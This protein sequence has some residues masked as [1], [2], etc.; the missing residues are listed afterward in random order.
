MAEAN[1][2]F[3]ESKRSRKERDDR[4]LEKTEALSDAFIDFTFVKDGK[5]LHE[6]AQVAEL[7]LIRA[8]DQA[9]ADTKRLLAETQQ[10]LSDTK[11]ELAVFTGLLADRNKK[12]KALTEVIKGATGV[13]L[14]IRC[15]RVME[16]D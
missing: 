16:T 3:E 9:L 5:V 6:L 10:E 14:D 12:H 7:E 15:V 13:D 2:R 8:K 4:G 1:A 11:Q